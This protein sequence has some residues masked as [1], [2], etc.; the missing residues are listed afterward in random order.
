MAL[1]KHALPVNK[2]LQKYILIKQMQTTTN[3]QTNG[4][5]NEQTDERTDGRTN[6]RTDEQTDGRTRTKARYV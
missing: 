2:P 4:R 5:T 6:R 1:K 3:K